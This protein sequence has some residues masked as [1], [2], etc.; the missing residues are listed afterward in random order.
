VSAL[1]DWF[2][3]TMA[4][5]GVFGSDIRLLDGGLATE[6]ATTYGHANIHV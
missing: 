5:N 6:L 3:V 4:A 1:I 2:A